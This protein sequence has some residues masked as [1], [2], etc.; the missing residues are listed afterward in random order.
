[1]L[2]YYDLV[3]KFDPDMGVTF[4]NFC[5][6]PIYHQMIAYVRM[7]RP[8]SSLDFEMGGSVEES[9]VTTL[10]DIIPDSEDLEESIINKDYIDLWLSKLTPFEKGVVDMFVEQD[11][12]KID[13][14]KATGLNT[15]Q[16][17]KILK[18][19]A[20]K[21]KGEGKP[22][23]SKWGGLT[24]AEA[25]EI[26]YATELDM[27]RAGDTDTTIH[28]KTGRSRNTLRLIKQMI[29]NGDIIL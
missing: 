26:K 6:K 15:V 5:W 9:N 19:A 25:T 1:M 11:M 8:H 18:P 10:G 21:K 13:I 27:M 4:G 7:F 29:D 23:E 14:R 2:I 3:E 20:I 12:K 17:N 22:Y 24:K 28:L 16:L